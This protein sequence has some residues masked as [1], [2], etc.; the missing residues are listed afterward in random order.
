MHVVYSLHVISLPNWATC[1]LMVAWQHFFSSFFLNFTH[2][3]RSSGLSAFYSFL[4]SSSPTVNFF[5]GHHFRDH[6]SSLC[7]CCIYNTV[8]M[9]K[10]ELPSTCSGDGSDRATK[11]LGQVERGHRIRKRK[12]NWLQWTNDIAK[13][14]KKAENIA[15]AV[16][17]RWTSRVCKTRHDKEWQILYMGSFIWGWNSRST[18]DAHVPLPYVHEFG[19]HASSC[20]TYEHEHII[21]TASQ[22][23]PSAHLSAAKDE[24]LMQKR[25]REEGGKV[26][27]MKLQMIFRR[28][29][30][31]HVLFAQT[32]TTH[33]RTERNVQA[34]FQRAIT[35]YISTCTCLSQN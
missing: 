9:N 31:E 32:N 12:E 28:F 13:D 19:C 15:G 35:I 33:T 23:T 21:T 17:E 2:S 3:L 27:T 29:I 18:S 34:Y 7:L 11:I 20:I 6:F 16:D 14:K 10:H 1:L 8:L 30:D 22:G 5:F 26:K 4:R 24:R 25:E